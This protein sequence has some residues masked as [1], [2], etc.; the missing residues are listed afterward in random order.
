[1]IQLEAGKF[2]HIFN[3]GIN[4]CNL[5]I[6]KDNYRHFLHL[7]E[8]YID[9]IAETFAWCLLRNHFHLLIRIRLE[10]EIKLSSLP[11]PKY[12]DLEHFQVKLRQ[13]H[14]YFSDLFNAYSKAINKQEC[15]SGALFERPFKRLKVDHSEYFRNLIIYIHR[16]SELH[17]FTDNFKDYPWS[18]YGSIIS[19][20][21][22]RLNRQR[23]IGWFN[24]IAEFKSEHEIVPAYEVFKSFCLE[25]ED[26]VIPEQEG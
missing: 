2:Y 11:I 1:M 25:A 23:V 7:Y 18:S 21:P 6:T 17:G 16:N 22:T 15:R 26:F 9:P 13:P 24:S 12:V 3:R 5:F 20:Q 10:N 19:V 14:F 8:K 4:G